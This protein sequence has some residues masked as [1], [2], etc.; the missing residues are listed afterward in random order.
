MAGA[1]RRRMAE[2][3]MLRDGANGM[4]G[5]LVENPFDANQRP[6]PRQL[7]SAAAAIR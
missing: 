6:T 4:D 2:K 5:S 3:R 1:A 7:K